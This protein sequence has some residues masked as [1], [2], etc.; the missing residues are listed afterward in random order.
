M[1]CA[2]FLPYFFQERMLLGPAS[3]DNP[4]EFQLVVVGNSEEIRR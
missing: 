1:P 4:T 2:C 3:R